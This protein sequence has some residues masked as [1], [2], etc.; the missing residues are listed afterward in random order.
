[1]NPDRAERIA[2]GA[3]LVQQG[4]T[5]RDAAAKVGIPYPTLWKHAETLDLDEQREQIAAR[6]V[7]L[8]AA[9]IARMARDIDRTEDR[10]V[11]S[12]TLAAAKIG[13]VLEQ[14]Q[15]A[16]ASDLAELLQRLAQGGN[17]VSIGVRVEAGQKEP[18]Q[19]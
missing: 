18:E 13:G 14:H 12:W 16:K 17:T 3:A 8:A 6:A 7:E 19:R 10:H 9:G 2:Q 11:A 4:H 15:D 5:Y 1:M